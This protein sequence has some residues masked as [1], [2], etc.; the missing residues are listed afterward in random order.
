MGSRHMLL[1]FVSALLLT[2]TTADAWADAKSS[3]A[4]KR[5]KADLG[6]KDFSG[7]SQFTGDVAFSIPL[8]SKGGVDVTLRYNSNLHKLLPA[9]NKFSPSGWLGLGWKLDL[10]SIQADISNTADSSDDKYFFV[11]SDVS[12]ELIV[13]SLNAFTLR[14]YR[15][16]KITREVV[17]G[18]VVGWTVILEDGTI[19]R[20][21]NYNIDNGTFS[22]DDLPTSATRCFVGCGGLVQTTL[23][24]NGTTSLI[25]YQWDLSDIQD[26]NGDHT[27]IKYQQ[28]KSTLSG[29]NLQFTLESYPKEIADRQKSTIQ[30]E[31]YPTPLL[32]IEPPVVG[33]GQFKSDSRSLQRIVVRDARSQVVSGYDFQFDSINVLSRSSQQNKKLFLRR[34][35]ELD[36]TL[37]A[38]KSTLFD[39]AGVREELSAQTETNPGAMIRIL[40]PE[41]GEITYRYQNDFIITERSP[42]VGDPGDYWT[43]SPTG[44][45]AADPDFWSMSGSD[46]FVVWKSGAMTA[47]RWSPNN[48]Y[49]VDAAFPFAGV[50]TGGISSYWV[51]NDYVVCKHS[52]NKLSVAKRDGEGWRLQLLEQGS[53]VASAQIVSLAS[54]FFVYA[55]NCSGNPADGDV[56]VA[57]FSNDQNW[58]IRFLGRRSIGFNGAGSN[59]LRT[60][61]RSFVFGDTNPNIYRYSPSTGNWIASQISGTMFAGGPEYYLEKADANNTKIWKWGGSAWGYEQFYDATNN[62]FGSSFVPG[63]NYFLIVGNGVNGEPARVHVSNPISNGWETVSLTSLLNGAVVDRHAKFVL[64]PDFFVITWREDTYWKVGVIRNRDGQWQQGSLVAQYSAR[65]RTSYPDDTCIPVV[66]GSTVFIEIHERLNALELHTLVF[67]NEV[68]DDQQLTR[69]Q[70]NTNSPPTGIKPFLQPGANFT[71]CIV[72]PNLR[73]NGDAQLLVWKRSYGDFFREVYSENVLGGYSYRVSTKM[74]SD[75][76]SNGITSTF[77]FANGSYDE[78]INSVRFNKRTEHLPGGNGRTES[79][80]YNDQGPGLVDEFRPNPHY[81]Y[82]DGQTYLTRAIDNNGNTVNE[83]ATDY[84]VW[85]PGSTTAN[86]SVNPIADFDKGGWYNPY[87]AE[88]W[89]AIDEGATLNEADYIESLNPVDMAIVQLAAPDGALVPGTDIQI[90]VDARPAQPN[91]ASAFAILLFED[92][93]AGLQYVTDVTANAPANSGFGPYYVTHPAATIS[94]P[95][96]LYVGIELLT[97]TLQVARIKCDLVIQVALDTAGSYSRSVWSRTIRDEVPSASSTTYNETNGLV[98]MVVDTNSAGIQRV[99][100]T[101]Y[102]YERASYSF[103]GTGKHMYSQVYSTTVWAGA[104][105]VE[106]KKWTLWGDGDGVWRPREEWAWR[107][108]GSANDQSAPDDPEE[109]AEAL[110]VSTIASYDAHGNPRQITDAN[111]IHTAT[112]YGY[113][114]TL[115]IGRFRNAAASS[116]F[117][118]V[119]DDSVTTGWSSSYGNWVIQNGT[120]RQTDSTQTGSWATPTR[121]T[122]VQIDDG[123]VEADI[124]FDNSGSYRYAMIAKVVDQTSYLRFECRKTENVVR[125]HAMAPG[126]NVYQNQSFTFDENR[127]YHLRGEIEGTVAR[128]YIDGRK[129]VEL[130]AAQVDRPAGYLGLGTFGTV[131][132]FD[133]IRFS[134]I[135]SLAS[136]QVYDRS[137]RLQTGA[138]DESGVLQSMVYDPANRRSKLYLRAEG[139]NLLTNEVR[140][141]YSRSIGDA[142]E[143]GRPN[144]VENLAPPDSVSVSDFANRY[145]WSR[146]SYQSIHDSSIDIVFNI[147]YAGETTAQLGTN[148]GWNYILRWL[149]SAHTIAR[150]DFYPTSA[151]GGLPHVLAYESDGY[152][153]CVQ[154]N[155]STDRFQ[156]QTYFGS[157]WNSPMTFDLPAPPDHWYTI[158]LEKTEGGD[159]YAFVY[160]K[161]SGRINK[162]GYVYRT[163]GYPAPWLTF[164]ISYT[165]TDYYYLANF[166]A[167][168]ADRSVAFFDG[169]GRELQ[170]Q[171]QLKLNSVVESGTLYDDAGRPYRVYKPFEKDYSGTSRHRFDGSYASNSDAYYN[172]M[173]NGDSHTSGYPYSESKYNPDPTS[174]VWKRSSPGSDWRMDGGHERQTTFGSNASTDLTGYAQNTLYRTSGVDEDATV[175]WSFT[176]KFGN[177]VGS[178]VDPS[179]LN[180]RTTMQFDV[181]G[182]R[183]ASV[184]PRGDVTTYAYDP[185]KRLRS[186]TSP[187]AGTTQY[188]Y[189][190]NG[191]L[192][193]VKDAAHTGTGANSVYLNSNSVSVP[194]LMSNQFTLTMPGKVTL[195]AR[196]ID[197]DDVEK[198]TLRIKANGAT[199]KTVETNHW[200]GASGN[201]ILPKGTYTYEVQASGPAYGSFGYTIA[202]QTGYEFVYYKYDAFGRLT[203]SGEYESS[204]ASANFTQANANNGAFPSSNCLVSSLMRYDVESVDSN[205]AAQRNFKGR[206]SMARSYRLGVLE[207]TTSYSYNP[208]GLVEWTVQTNSAGRV[209]TQKFDYDVQG[210]V[211]KK[212]FLDGVS[213]SYNLYTFYEYDQMGRLVK[214]STGP[215]ADGTSKTQEAA[216]T[217]YAG[218]TVKR[219]QLASV[220]GVDYRYNTRDWLTQ[221]NELDLDTAQD[222][223]RDGPGGSGVSNKDKFGML[224]GYQNQDRIGSAQNAT[225]H[226]NG[227]VSWQVYNMAEDSI[228]PGSPYRR[229]SRV[230]NTYSY[231]KAGRIL[232]SNFGFF[233]QNTGN[234][235]WGWYGTT[236]Y[237]ENGY[238]YDGNGNIT[239]VQRYGNTGALMDNLTYAYATGTNRLR[240]IL[241]TVTAGTFASDIDSQVTDNYAYDA[242]GSLQKDLQRDVAFVVNDIR[243]L[244]VSVWKASTAQEMKYYYDAGG[245]RIRKDIGSTDYYVNGPGG[246]TEAVVKSDASGAT[247]SILGRDNLGQVKRSGTTFARY[248][249]LKDH[250][251]TVKLT[252]DASCTTVGFDDYY[253]FGQQMEGRCF[254]STADA[255]YKYTSKERD[256]ESGYDYFGTRYYDARIGRWLCVDP[257][258]DK[259]PSFGS[260]NYVGGNPISQSDP[261]GADWYKDESGNMQFSPLV[262]STDRSK[263][264]KGQ[265]YVGPTHPDKG[266]GKIFYR[267]DGSI[268]YENERDAYKRA[269]SI[270][271][272]E[273]FMVLLRVAK[274]IRKNSNK[275]TPVLMTPDYKNTAGRSDPDGLYAGYGWSDGALVDGEGRM[276][277]AAGTGHTHP[278]NNPPSYLGE[279]GHVNDADVAYVATNIP[280]TINYVFGLSGLRNVYMFSGAI[281]SEGGLVYCPAIP[282]LT[283]LQGITQS[284]VQSGEYSPSKYA[285]THNWPTK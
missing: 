135:G 24:A 258:A 275:V 84:K 127:W 181:L 4:K 255:R 276:W 251:G 10:G 89:A 159:A 145:G 92:T 143:S 107:G 182:N 98:S 106:A 161:G 169:L 73:Q 191:N 95:S 205:A 189:D 14:E 212:S 209:W 259:Y 264:K 103:M 101:R 83:T 269:F 156:M 150:V 28:F 224:L 223:G 117:A 147:P 109:S 217:Y 262:T 19:C 267:K 112:V 85:F 33:I 46:F 74:Y 236:F 120:Y 61:G 71:V 185:L 239:G 193:L 257:L 222:P 138:S 3:T 168:L 40:L 246:Q 270:L 162:T 43:S 69:L 226:W 39:Y 283:A 173:D 27:T 29:S 23:P 248:Y 124:R 8:A 6:T 133:N 219:A 252:V 114:S 52:D 203:E 21:G 118:A 196:V 204:S 1:V 273:E 160:P 141:T 47:Y 76:F 63:A 62:T 16:W 122:A 214:V 60:S 281:N 215:N 56:K 234:G 80:T 263:L 36:N 142:Y 128:F 179:G 49:E 86:A 55:T 82:L 282:E 72:D 268:Y 32:W 235:V 129:V 218:G 113:D 265:T 96:H 111:G 167:G 152:R 121:N 67:R 208:F 87:F 136:L 44:A 125:I 190:P 285:N 174:R 2:F 178:I 194:T 271:G 42:Q 35:S 37:T 154:Y 97:G 187:D 177:A 155:P 108:D 123:V 228:E 20:Y 198:L 31:L 99:V 17:D 210:R 216:Y 279:S 170:A 200:S 227:N 249:F 137:S 247:H 48:V 230:G 171:R 53:L 197:I 5:E 201:I 146:G 153:F 105:D 237:D 30:F 79:F 58:N 132:S 274:E 139:R 188:L 130:N 256:S 88:L 66:S 261:D 26:V 266:L 250:L 11:G 278:G 280:S 229:T 166:Y 180:L 90:R 221:I 104:S 70:L 244:P 59:R 102:A 75:G 15:H 158:E 211:T 254:Q 116:S 77:E 25:P 253:P 199:I 34:V 206:L 260:F 272:K 163:S 192:R 78:D 93:G 100:E 65:P 140:Y 241:E 172:A 183:I 91:E 144:A 284:M 157:S 12:S 242:N 245:K 238:Q 45:L 231:D 148:G 213:A 115:P 149:T 233:S 119:F 13:D 134:P 57:T 22:L 207:L 240:H 51:C 151:T 110:R 94:D 232:G 68:W 164:A 176:D 131:A 7:E 54:D 50:T 64:G 41:G 18:T 126:S 81:R 277:P 195:D 165:N 186:K 38:L 184:T 220:Q 243:N 225:Q 175:T 202:C 9:E